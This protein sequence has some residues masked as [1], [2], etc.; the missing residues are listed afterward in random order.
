[1]TTPRAGS[2]LI[3]RLC[4]GR[5]APGCAAARIHPPHSRPP[6]HPAPAPLCSGRITGYTFTQGLS[7]QVNNLTNSG[8]E[9]GAVVD[10]AVGA[11]GNALQVGAGARCCCLLPLLSFV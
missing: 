11:G 1:M 9:L 6:P 3:P 5:P 7:V 10:A 2:E 4:T 8:D